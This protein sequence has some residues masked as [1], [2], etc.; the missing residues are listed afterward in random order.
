MKYLLTSLTIFLSLHVFGQ[1]DFRPAEQ[2]VKKV[3]R[4]GSDSHI[5]NN[6][7]GT[8]SGFAITHKLDC[9]VSRDVDGNLFQRI[10]ME[11]NAE[12]HTS[13]LIQY[14]LNTETF[15]FELQSVI[16]MSY[17]GEAFPS[18]LVIETIDSLTQQLVTLMEIDVYYD[19]MHRPDSMV[20]WIDDP[21]TGIFG[22]II[23]TKQVYSGDLLVQTRQ[24]FYISLFGFWAL[25]SETSFLY[26]GLD[27][28]IEQT[29]S[30]VD[31]FTMEVIPDMRSTYS[32]LANDKPETITN[33]F[34]TG[35]TWMPTDRV[36]H[37]Y[38]PN[39]T[40]KDEVTQ[41]NEGGNWV[42]NAWTQYHLEFV[43]DQ[44]PVTNYFWDTNIENWVKSDST[45]SLL[46]PVLPWENV[47]APRELSI[48][49]ALDLFGSGFIFIFVEGSSIL[50]AE[51]Y[52]YDPAFQAFFFSGNDLYYYSLIGSA[53]VNP[54][55]PDFLTVSPN[56]ARER[57]EIKFDL[58]S[59]AVYSAYAMSGEL[60]GQGPITKGQNTIHTTEWIPGIYC[61]RIDIE[62]GSQY[63]HKQVIR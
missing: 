42:N 57:F 12:L 19:G 24:W 28:L 22:P 54:V 62:N 3:A 1:T 44:I 63:L 16:S 7:A 53:Q 51:Y 15:N 13:R 33:Y 26:D 40:L 38:F 60:V 25:A 48:L 5:W 34:W 30:I 43:G 29:T 58:D 39:E 11:Y 21:F 2:I 4:I 20:I 47:A 35:D 49:D 14:G 37:V 41:L 6:L 31:L 32:Y 52:L 8:R 50:E 56:P 55:L 46:N 10:E 23:A 17:E 61:I 9:V 36:N 18:H 45:I 59:R 27:R